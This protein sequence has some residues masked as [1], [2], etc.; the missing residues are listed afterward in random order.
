MPAAEI[1]QSI[2]EKYNGIH[3]HVDGAQTWGGEDVDLAAMKCDSFSGSSHKWYMGPRETGLL[4]VKESAVENIE[5]FKTLT[6]GI[7]P[8][9]AASNKSKTLFDSAI[10]NNCSPCLDNSA[11]NYYDLAN[12]DDGSC[13][14]IVGC[15]DC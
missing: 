8:P 10:L 6:I 9:I 13:C 11:F 12:K 7:P 2:K 15:M 1:C 14:Y 5:F 4:F 3:I